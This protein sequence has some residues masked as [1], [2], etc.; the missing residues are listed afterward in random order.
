VDRLSEMLTAVASRHGGGRYLA[1]LKAEA[2]R[3][4]ARGWLIERART[5]RLRAELEEARR[6]RDEARIVAGELESMMDEP[7]ALPWQASKTIFN[8]GGPDA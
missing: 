5:K 2:I 7:Q 3:T 8:P 1:N 4:L 6:Q